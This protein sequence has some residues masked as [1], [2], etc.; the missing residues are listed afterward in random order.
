MWKV[1]RKSHVIYNHG[2]LKTSVY[3][4]SPHPLFKI[5][6]FFHNTSKCVAKYAISFEVTDSFI[7]HNILKLLRQEGRP[8]GPG[9]AATIIRIRSW[10][11]RLPRVN[12]LLKI[13]SR[14][15]WN[16]DKIKERVKSRQS[17]GK[18]T[19]KIDNQI[20]YVIRFLWVS[21]APYFQL[22]LQFAQRPRIDWYKLSCCDSLWSR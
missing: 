4:F 20:E 7:S 9:W 14:P 17:E 18:K 15:M 21:L 16:E 2:L 11:F 13:L 12:Y 22:Q 1:S 6:M 8:F 10:T 5:I 19:E 3:F